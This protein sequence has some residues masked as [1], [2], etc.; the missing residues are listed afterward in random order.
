MIPRALWTHLVKDL[1]IEWRSKDAIN[2]MLFFALLVVVLFSISFDP[3]GA[4]ARDIAGGVLCVA[5][6]FASVSALNQAWAREIRHQVMDA[7][8]MAPSSGAELFLAKVLADFAP[9]ASARGVLLDDLYIAAPD[10]ALRGPRA[11]APGEDAVAPSP[12]GELRVGVTAGLAACRDAGALPA[13][14]YGLDGKPV[15]LHVLHSWG[16]GAA[17]FVHDL[18][19]GDAQRHHIVLNARGNFHRHAFGETIELVDDTVSPAPLRSL[20][21]PNP[22]RSTT[23]GD[24]SYREFFDAILRDFHVDAVMVSSLIGHSLDVLRSGLPTTH[25][26]HDFYPLWPLL[27]RN[28]DDANLQFDAKLLAAS[29][30]WVIAWIRP[31]ASTR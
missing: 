8:R 10:R 11:V 23:L 21:L 15:V 18:A 17:R 27:H 9:L 1:R 16:G 4:F 30:A 12:L 29:G 26:V 13:A 2:S 24:P 25:F 5:T 3:Q 7:Q 14:Y 28:L 31:T 22:I 6:M 20:T 19:R